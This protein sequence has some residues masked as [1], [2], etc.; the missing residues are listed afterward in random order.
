[1]KNVRVVDNKVEL[2]TPV[3]L[4]DTLKKE[5]E[6]LNQEIIEMLKVR[7]E[8]TT[9]DL[10]NELR[11]RHKEFTTATYGFKKMSPF[12]NS[13]KGI[14]LEGSRVILVEENAKN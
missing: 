9:S 3:K 12:V 14:K 2:Q 13:L 8:I 5:K 7:K 10:N 6:L 11:K 1:M 4:S